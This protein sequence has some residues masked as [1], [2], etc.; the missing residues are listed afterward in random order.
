MWCRRL[1]SRGNSSKHLCRL[2]A[3]RASRIDKPSAAASSARGESVRELA[4][5]GEVAGARPIL[6]VCCLQ[7]LPAKK[8][9]GMLFVD[10]LGE[11][12]SQAG[13]QNGKNHQSRRGPATGGYASPSEPA[14]ELAEA[15]GRSWK[16]LQ[17]DPHQLGSH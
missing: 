2:C 7:K 15:N 11:S 17:Y 14:V 5:G 16:R 1:K 9:S 3:F 13:V 8:G 4:A 12:P 10:T 6:I